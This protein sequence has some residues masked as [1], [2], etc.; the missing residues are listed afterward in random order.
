MGIAAADQAGLVGIG[1]K[2][3]FQLQSQLERRADV[4]AVEHAILRRHHFVEIEVP[5]LK[6]GKFVVRR[7]EGMGLAV[8]L[9]LRRFQ[10]WLVAGARLGVVPGHGFSVEGF[11]RVHD[12]IAQVAVVRDGEHLATR[13][14]RV[15]VHVLPQV[16]WILAVEGGKGNDLVH[17]VRVV[18]EN[19][20]AMKVVAAGRGSP[21]EAVQRGEN[22]R[23]VPLLGC[24]DGVRPGSGCEFAGVKDRLAGLHGDDRFD[25]GFH[26]LLRARL[27]HLVPPLALRVGEEIGAAG[28]NLI[29][30]AH[31]FRM[32][33]DGEPVQRPVDFDLHAVIDRDFSASGEL[34]EVVGAQRYPKHS[35]VEGVA[36]VVVGSAP[37]HPVRDGGARL[38]RRLLWRSRSERDRND[39]SFV[40]VRYGWRAT[41]K[42]G[43]N[44]ISANHREA[45]DHQRHHQLL[46][47]C[48]IN[49]HESSFTRGCRAGRSSRT[50][51]AV[52]EGEHGASADATT[53]YILD[54]SRS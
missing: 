15:R 37:V 44:R 46:E 1:S 10:Q 4:V 23:L 28:P 53:S 52:S 3:G 26:A 33:G 8:T 29:G 38:L 12:A 19:D 54:C 31:I 2:L 36:S 22:A 5:A 18:A 24:R 49:V 6:V 42:S 27:R 9:D 11:R 48:E 41:V 13:L 43:T 39:L 50:I 47:V 7:E 34:E 16:R 45:E 17:A 21:F 14:R 51:L 20:G 25:G 35:R 40:R 30:Y 32:V